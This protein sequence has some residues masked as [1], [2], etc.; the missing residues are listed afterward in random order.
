M[1][2]KYTICRFS[3]PGNKF[4]FVSKNESIININVKLLRKNKL[5]SV[6]PRKLEPG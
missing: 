6:E 3:L 2:R 5:Q 1:N 4:S